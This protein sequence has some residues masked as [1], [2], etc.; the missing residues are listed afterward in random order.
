MR[1]ISASL[2]ATDRLMQG[3]GV[4][5]FESIQSRDPTALVGLPLIWLCEALR[6]LGLRV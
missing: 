5:L 1:S 6:G 3:L 4:T 2:C